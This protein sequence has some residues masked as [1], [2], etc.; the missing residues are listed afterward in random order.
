MSSFSDE[1]RDFDMFKTSMLTYMIPCYE[2][3]L[4][5]LSPRPVSQ[6]YFRWGISSNGFLPRLICLT[7][8]CTKRFQKST[9]HPSWDHSRDPDS[10]SGWWQLSYVAMATQ[11]CGG[12]PMAIGSDCEKE[13]RRGFCLDSCGQ[14]GSRSGRYQAALSLSMLCNRNPPLP[15]TQ[16]LGGGHAVPCNVKFSQC[17]L[18]TTLLHIYRFGSVSDVFVR[19]WP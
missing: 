11:G 2:F 14:W 10:I 18:H 1:K 17:T 6:L 15:L 13:V 8:T 4:K 5:P 9:Q 19:G 7:H 3:T 12:L 16:V